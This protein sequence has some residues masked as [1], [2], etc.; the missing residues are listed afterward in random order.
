MATAGYW[1]SLGK[2]NC[3]VC[4]LFSKGEIQGDTVAWDTSEPEQ[5]ST[6]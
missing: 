1:S 5:G 3:W 2:K 4:L 6:A